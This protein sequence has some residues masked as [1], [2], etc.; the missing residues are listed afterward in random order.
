LAHKNPKQV[1]RLINKIYSTSDFFYITVFGNNSSIEDWR[2]ML[3]EFKN[4]NFFTT[5]RPKNAWGQFPIINATLDSMNVFASFNFDYFINLSG[6]CYPLKSVDLIKEFFK[7]KN[8]AYMEHF[9]MP[10][11]SP[12]SWGKRGGLN[13]IEYSYY[14]NP[15]H[16]WKSHSPMEFIKLP[17]LHKRLPYNLQ[18]YGGSSYFC[19][20]KKHINF[21]LGYLKNKSNLIDFFRHTINV[22]EIFFQTIL[23][24]SPLKD[25]VINDNLRYIDWSKKGKPLPAVLTIDDVDLLLNSQK[26][27]ARKFDIEVDQ[28]ILDSIDIDIHKIRGVSLR[29][30]NNV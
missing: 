14:R 20:P 10:K 25:T 15:F 19:L 30:I 9:A 24:N 29:N 12:K 22:D 7:S 26:L 23:M 1:N 21:V 2:K 27:F 17:R 5:Y 13:R 6:Q 16:I 4:N 28:Q 8:F 11:D 3:E 18:P